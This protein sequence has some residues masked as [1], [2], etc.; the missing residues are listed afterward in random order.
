MNEDTYDDVFDR[1]QLT[2]RT[3]L[4]C[5]AI[6]SNILVRLLVF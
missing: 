5:M 6:N 3:C 4:Y 2:T 1:I